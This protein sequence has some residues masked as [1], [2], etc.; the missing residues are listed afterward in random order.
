ML[1]FCFFF[2]FYMD[3]CVEKVQVTQSYQRENKSPLDRCKNS[4]FS[5]THMMKNK[6]KIKL[7]N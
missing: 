4:G 7:L 3:F 6:G 1:V 5:D 2:S